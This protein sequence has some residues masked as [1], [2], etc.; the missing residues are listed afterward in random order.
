MSDQ[1]DPN[2]KRETPGNVPTGQARWKLLLLAVIVA[3][4]VL[5]FDFT[6]IDRL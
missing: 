6:V 2:R 5:L 4:L 1:L 3:L